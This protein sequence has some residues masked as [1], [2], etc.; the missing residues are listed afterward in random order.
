M[1]HYR[2]TTWCPEVLCSK[3]HHYV[4]WGGGGEGACDRPPQLPDSDHA[5]N[6]GPLA[7]PTWSQIITEL[8]QH[9]SNFFLNYFYLENHNLSH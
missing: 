1:V 9:I 3:C 2:V 8:F 7:S 5:L 6:I 4:K